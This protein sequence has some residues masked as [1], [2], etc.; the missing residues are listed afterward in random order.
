MEDFGSE[1]SQGVIDSVADRRR[2]GDG[3][4]FAKPLHAKFRV[5]RKR[6]H[7]LHPRRGHLGRTREEIVGKGRGERLTRGVEVHFF[8]ERGADALSETAIDLAVH[9]HRIDELAAILDDDVVED[10]DVPGLGIDG[11]SGDM[12]GVA[13]GAR[14]AAGLIADRRLE[15]ARIDRSR[16]ILRAPI[17]GVRNLREA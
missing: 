1:R 12:G 8:V 13:E 14:V 10:L 16:E 15:A 6:L 9:H 7:M 3:A 4:A 11:D 17:P 5:G 2:R